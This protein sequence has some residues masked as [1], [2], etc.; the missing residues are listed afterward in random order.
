[1]DICYKLL[2]IDDNMDCQDE[3]Y[4]RI[5]QE[6]VNRSLIPCVEISDGSNHL[7]LLE[8]EYDMYL[9][10]LNLVAGISGADI[11]KAIRNIRD[12]NRRLTDIVL[13]SVNEEDLER[14]RKNRNLDGTYT[15]T[16]KE[17]LDKVSGMLDK[18]LRRTLNP[19]SLRGMLLHNFCDFEHD[20]SSII[21]KLSHI[22]DSKIKALVSSEAKRLFLEGGGGLRNEY[23]KYKAIDFLKEIMENC[24]HLVGTFAKIEILRV[25]VVNGVAGPVNLKHISALH[26]LRDTRNDLSHSRIKL[27]K[28]GEML[29]LTKKGSIPFKENKCKSVREDVYAVKSMITE[30][31]TR[32]GITD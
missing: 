11:V 26:N 27:D 28:R 29:V 18:Q 16:R 6:I 20:L 23:E 9:I 1:M 3:K 22:S 30:I 21:A 7:E 12:M 5:K 15:A 13:Y 17:L 14:A 32:L 31:K 19:L 8:K 25:M 24:P 4:K 2:I 10:D